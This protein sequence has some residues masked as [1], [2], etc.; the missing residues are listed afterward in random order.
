MARTFGCYV[1]GIDLSG[2]CNCHPV[3]SIVYIIC[4]PVSA[5][6]CCKPRTFPGALAAT[7]GSGT[8]AARG[9]GACF[10]PHS[11]PE[12]GNLCSGMPKFVAGL[13]EAG[14]RVPVQA[15]CSL[16]LPRP[17]APHSLT[18]RL[19]CS[20]FAH[21]LSPAAVH[22]VN[23]ILTALERAAA[24]GNGDK[25]RPAWRLAKGGDSGPPAGATA[26]CRA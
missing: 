12:G 8:R 11:R 13:V 9:R 7:A 16:G 22:A 23:M 26:G 14:R 17:S 15:R 2:A 21:T 20:W 1:Y 6:G 4:A 18:P 25:V 19:R 5:A 24:A 10:G 3:S